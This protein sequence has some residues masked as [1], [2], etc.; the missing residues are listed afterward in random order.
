MPFPYSE[1]PS[2]TP[3]Q[4]NWYKFIKQA[5]KVVDLKGKRKGKKWEMFGIIVFII[6][7]HRRQRR[8]FGTNDSKEVLR[9]T[10]FLDFVHHPVF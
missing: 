5:Y 1:S 9:I 10:G 4:K 7:H 3:I 2:F 8:P 6:T